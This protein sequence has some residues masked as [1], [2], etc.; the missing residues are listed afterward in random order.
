VNELSRAAYIFSAAFHLLVVVLVFTGLPQLFKEK[1]PEEMPIVVQLVNIA[2]ETRAT[3]LAQD[4]PR[5]DA[6]PD[7]EPAPPAPPTPKP[8]LPKPTP[9]PPPPPPPPAPKPP[10]PKPEPPKPPEPKPEPP[11]PPPPPPEPKPPEPKPPEPKPEPPK[12]EPPK[13]PEPKPPEAKPKPKPEPPKE[14]KAE[15]PK[16]EQPQKT[17]QADFDALLKNLTRQKTA[18]QQ[19]PPDKPTK[20]ASAAPAQPSAQPLNAP[21]GSELSA[22]EKDLVAAQIAECW[23]PP[24][25]AK[26]AKDLVIKLS[27]FMR[28]DGTVEDARIVDMVRYAADGFF[29]AAADSAVRAVKNPRC[30]PLKLPLNKYEQW[31][32]FTFNFNPKDLL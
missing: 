30:S 11:P 7:A 29:R 27:V 23:N 32:N 14:Q 1:P 3:K 5:P 12:P 24:V 26:D 25:G 19:T 18:P 9:A 8:E 31:K 2:P 4:R 17:Q 10:E 16:Q 28:P 13:P 21:L 20:T 6:K 15:P 22:S